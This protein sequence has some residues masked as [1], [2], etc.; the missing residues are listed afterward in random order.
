M[1]IALDVTLSGD[2]PGIKPEEAP[3]VMG[4]GPAIILA[5]ASGRGIL[6]QQSIKDLLIKAGDENEINYRSYK[7]FIA[8]F[9]IFFGDYEKCLELLSHQ[10]LEILMV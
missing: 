6:T 9:L 4:K 5:D 7:L 8:F 3:V 10:N 2:H 1:A